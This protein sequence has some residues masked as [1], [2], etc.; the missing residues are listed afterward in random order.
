MPSCGVAVPPAIP[1]PA[2][3]ALALP[4]PCI[5][6]LVGPS[7]AGK[8]TWA[9]AH[10]RSTEV[11]SSDHLRAVVGHGEDDLAA[12]DDAFGL[13]D[14]IILQRAA[15][16]LTTVIDT[17][18]LDGERRAGYRELA[19]RHDLPCIAIAF[20]VDPTVC[21]ERNRQRPRPIPAA[22]LNSQLARWRQVRDHLDTEGFAMVVRPAAVREVPTH[23]ASAIGRTGTE[24]PRPHP[25]PASSVR[26]G[27]HV[28]AFPG[29]DIAT[30]LGDVAMAAESAGFDSL[31]VMDHVRQIPQVG[32]DWDP[33]LESYTTLAWL[34]ARTTRVQLGALVTAITF[35]NVAHLAKIIATLD[36][37]SAGRARCGLGLAWYEREHRGY[38]WPFPPTAD[39]YAVLEDALQLLPRMWGPGA[40]PY[41]G[42]VLQVPETICYPRPVQDQ[43]PMLVGGGGERRT[44]R[45]AARHA[46]AINIMGSPEVVRHKVEVLRHHCD[47]VGRDP[48]SVAV[49]HLAPT[50]VGRDRDELDALVDQLRPARV[51]PEQFRARAHAGTVADQIDRV[52]ELV[53]CGVGEII[54]S[55]PDLALDPVGAVERFAPIIAAYRPAAAPPAARTRSSSTR[56]SPT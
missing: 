10:F 22:A 35:R 37:L 23:L 31:W 32:R 49:T 43:I 3:A 45:L 33:M 30:T 24:R 39:R 26:F 36:V 56:S 12:S 16:R 13:L 41:A 40:K 7:A 48:A 19:A 17:L 15:R 34:A 11:V 27:L 14:A 28:A 5:V 21:R 42:R 54:V 6:V 29:A 51:P 47:D 25:E 18:G 8:S 50:L 20:E 9:A 2:D 4:T 1:K 55:L 44:L 38:G 53:A 52:R 46:D